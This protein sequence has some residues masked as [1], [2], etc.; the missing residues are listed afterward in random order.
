MP[1]IRKCS[2]GVYHEPGTK[3]FYVSVIDG[4]KYNILLGPFT[5]HPQ[6]LVMV[7]S[8]RR[9]AGKLDPKSHFYAFGTVGIEVGS[10]GPGLL[11]DQFP[12]L[13]F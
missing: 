4:P 13:T 1:A 6:A 2:C 12:E 3:V 10:S 11:N 7:D 8:V 5:T 9:L